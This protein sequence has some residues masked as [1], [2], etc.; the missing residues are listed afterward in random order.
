MLKAHSCKKKG[1]RGMRR[2]KKVMAAIMAVSLIGGTIVGCGTK[3]AVTDTATTTVS[4]KTEKTEETNVAKAEEGESKEESTGMATPKGEFPISKEKI[5]LTFMAAADNDIFFQENYK[6]SPIIQAYEEKFGVNLEFIFLPNSAEAKNKVIT[7]MASGNYPDGVMLSPQNT[8]SRSEI[9]KYGVEEGY[10]ISLS[11]YI[12]EFGDNIYEVFERTPAYEAAMTAPDGNI[13]AIPDFQENGHNAVYPKMY[14]NTQWL[15]NLGLD[16]P[17]DTESFYQVLKAF[18][19]QDANGNGDPND[20]IPLSGTI[21]GSGAVEYWLMNSFINTGA[22]STT[23]VTRTYLSVIDDQLQFVADKDE[24]REGLVWMNKLYEDGLIDPAA[25]TQ[26]Q[27][28]LKQTINLQEGVNTIGAFTADHIQVVG[29]YP[30][31]NGILAEY[32]AL[33]PLEGPEGVQYQ[34]YTAFGTDVEGF[35][36]AIFDTCEHPDVAYRVADALLEPMAQNIR[37]SREGWRYV[38]VEDQGLKNILGEPLVYALQTLPGDATQDEKE[39]YWLN[40]TNFLHPTAPLYEEQSS[41]IQEATEEAYETV[42]E[43]FLAAQAMKLAEYAPEV[44]LPRELFFVDDA[45]TKRF[46]EL[47]V[48]IVQH[49]QSNTAKFITGA[50]SLSE[51]DDYVEK[52]N[53]YGLEEYVSLYRESYNASFGTEY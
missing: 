52:L 20:E 48:S 38:N 15:E 11:P 10:F 30:G 34:P 23:S 6:D 43:T 41:M 4:A 25:F 14:I 47:K 44:T 19:E 29:S 1:G 46:G 18:K 5:T 53:A 13:Y 51:W 16:M 24:Y 26:D 27:A 45:S 33:M 9:V 50:R 7:A 49:V 17:T 31:T 32:D 21:S 40:F 37:Y 28:S 22:K 3:D 36:F 35:A 39:E 2:S 12:E 8:L 42:G